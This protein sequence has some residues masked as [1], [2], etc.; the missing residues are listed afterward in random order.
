MRRYSEAVKADV[1]SRMS[2]PHRERGRIQ[3]DRRV[4]RRGGCRAS[5]GACL[6]APAVLPE[7]GLIHLDSFPQ[8]VS[9]F[10]STHGPLDLFMQ[11]P[12][13]VVSLTPKWRLSQR[14]KIPVLA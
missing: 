13:C 8:H 5:T 4:A 12:G 10:R 7:I 1:R 6:A 14:R 9:V 11:Q 3:E 2:P